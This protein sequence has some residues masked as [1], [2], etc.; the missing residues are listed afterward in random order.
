M[1]QIKAKENCQSVEYRNK[2]YGWIFKG[3]VEYY[4]I[5]LLHHEQPFS[6]ARYS[7]V[8]T[9]AANFIKERVQAACPHCDGTLIPLSSID[10]EM[11]ESCHTYFTWELK[12]GQKSVLIEGKVGGLE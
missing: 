11:C 2:Q 12:N 9:H 8:F 3:P 5:S 4:F 1:I 10:K 6:H 7:N